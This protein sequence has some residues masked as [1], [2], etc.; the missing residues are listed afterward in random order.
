MRCVC[1]DREMVEEPVKEYSYVQ[2]TPSKRYKVLGWWVCNC[3]KYYVMIAPGY[4]PTGL[5]EINI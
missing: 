3:K 5:Y 2:E 1:C 4:T